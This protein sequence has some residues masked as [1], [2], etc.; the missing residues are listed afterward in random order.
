MKTTTNILILVL[1]TVMQSSLSAQV[2]S[3]SGSVVVNNTSGTVIVTNTVEANSGATVQNGGTLELTDLTNAGTVEGNGTYTVA[4]AFTNSGTFT[5]GSSSITFTGSGVQT[6]PGVGFHN[7]TITNA[8]VSSLAGTSSISG[9]LSV[10]GGTF[11]LTTFTANRLTLGGTF[12]L[13]ASCTLRIGGDGTTLPSNFATY[14]FD[15]ASRVEYYGTN[16]TMPGG[17]YENLTVDGSGT[18]I[19]LSADVDVVGDLIITDGTLDLGIY[20]AD[21]TTSGGTL[22]VGAGGSLI[23]GGT[24]P[25]PA[26]YTTYTF[27]AASTVEFSGT[28][29]TIG[30]FNFGN[31]TVSASGTLTLANGGTIGIAGTFTPGAGTYVTTNNTID[32]N[33]AGAQTVA[34]FAYNNLS[35]STSGTK[36]FASGTTS[37]AGTFSVSGATADATTNTSNINYSGTGAQTI[38]PMTYYG[39]T[40]SNGGTKTITGAVVVDQNMVTN[41]GSVIVIDVPGSLTIHGDLDNSGDFTNNGT[42]SMIP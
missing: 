15:P 41:A 11:D 39:L 33:N 35:L 17:T 42:L 14:D 20:T 31:L 19:T 9:D 22:S 3:T 16:Q 18:T 21:R 7:I 27:D 12:T 28:N 30:A 10:T 32:Y 34:A 25:M 38:V 40:F 29:H 24:N 1:A 5:P 26:N 13:A 23:I 4:G 36:T 2:I 6:I 37:I 8:G